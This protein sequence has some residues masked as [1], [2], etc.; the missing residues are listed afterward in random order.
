[1][2]L[3]DEFQKGNVVWC[4]FIDANLWNVITMLIQFIALCM[5]LYIA[6]RLSQTETHPCTGYVQTSRHLLI[7]KSKSYT[8]HVTLFTLRQG[9]SAN[10]YNNIIMGNYL[11]DP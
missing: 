2:Q 8:V 6:A 5:T 4:V 11:G 10:Q 9:L 7:C 3:Q 1:M